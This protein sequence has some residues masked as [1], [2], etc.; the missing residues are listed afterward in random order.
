MPCKCGSPPKTDRLG[1]AYCPTCRLANLRTIPALPG[2][3]NLRARMTDD[4]VRE[5]RRWWDAGLATQAELSRLFALDDGQ[6]S[7]I[8]RRKRWTHV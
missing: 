1:R 7:R 6:V 5:M 4:L 8:V 2:E 3:R